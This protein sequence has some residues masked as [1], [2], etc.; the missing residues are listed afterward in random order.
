VSL[1]YHRN[2]IPLAQ[3]LLNVR[4]GTI[5]RR[6]EDLE[7]MIY[8]KIRMTKMYFEKK[9]GI[10]TFSPAGANLVMLH[11]SHDYKLV[12]HGWPRRCPCKPPF[13]NKEGKIFERAGN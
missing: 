11:A 1:T 8:R 4:I 3:S 5:E 9:R 2:F 10:E 6:F 12:A 7:I 13:R